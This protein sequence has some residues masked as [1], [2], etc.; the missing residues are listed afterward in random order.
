M[1][2]ET[3]DATPSMTAVAARSHS[4]GHAAVPAPPKV[5]SLRFEVSLLVLVDLL[6]ATLA[7]VVGLDTRFHQGT[8]AVRGIHYGVVALGFP[9]L[10]VAAMAIGGAYDRRFL[11]SG[12]VEYRRVLNAA[13]WL[14]AATAITS[15]MFN[16][17]LSRGFVGLTLPLA[18]V[19]TLWCRVIVRRGLHR[20]LADGAAIH[21]V[22]VVG[23][24]SVAD[25]LAQHLTRSHLSGHV[26]VGVMEA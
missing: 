15:Y 10:W 11:A 5:I 18:F 7:A 6:V 2:V 14:G 21:R 1:T 20:F 26:V 16:L 4:R 13:V 24:Q 9:I 17:Q 23:P 25:R 12:G 22:L 8:A 3:Y 19:V